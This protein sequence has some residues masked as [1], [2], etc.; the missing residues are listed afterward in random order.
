MPTLSGRSQRRLR[1]VCGCQLE[2]ARRCSG[3]D[4]SHSPMSRR[5]NAS[6]VHHLAEQK[7]QLLR[8]RWAVDP[9]GTGGNL[10]FGR[11]LHERPFYRI[12]ARVRAMFDLSSRT[13]SAILNRSP[14]IVFDIGNEREQQL[15]LR[16]PVGGAAARGGTSTSDRAGSAS[17]PL[18]KVRKPAS[19][20]FKARA[21]VQIGEC[22][23]EAQCDEPLFAGFARF[24]V[25][26]PPSTAT[27]TVYN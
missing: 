20:R 17:A 11:P 25:S 9:G 13:S 7:S 8:N 23:T 21:I 14:M 18:R 5:A 2:R 6:S 27:Q 1:R 12:A 15:R 10:S 24:H 26:P 4:F 22:Q 3:S 19:N 16:L